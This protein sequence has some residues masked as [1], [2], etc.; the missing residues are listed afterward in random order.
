LL[1]VENYQEQESRHKNDEKYATD[2]CLVKA[3]SWSWKHCG[4][5]FAGV[6]ARPL[7]KNQVP[8]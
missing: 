5:R 3:S 7:I 2:L 4:L 8:C 1:V 6:L